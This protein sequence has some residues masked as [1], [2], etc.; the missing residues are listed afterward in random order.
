M[1]IVY[2]QQAKKGKRLQLVKL[3]RVETNMLQAEKSLWFPCNVRYMID[4]DLK[5][6][7]SLDKELKLQ[8][9]LWLKILPKC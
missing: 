1:Q 8:K 6:K 7:S 9:M 2:V 4:L 3:G 5:T